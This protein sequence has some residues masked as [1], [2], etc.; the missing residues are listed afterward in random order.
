V[1]ECAR[2]YSYSQNFHVH[3]SH[4]QLHNGIEMLEAG[5]CT[6]CTWTCTLQASGEVEPRRTRP[7]RPVHRISGKHCIALFERD[8]C[9]SEALGLYM[10]SARADAFT[11]GAWHPRSM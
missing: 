6:R 5:V 2:S 10:L 8:L 4:I 3:T 7:L 11:T 9:A 1:F